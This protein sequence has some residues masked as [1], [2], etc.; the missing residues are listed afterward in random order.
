[1]ARFRAVAV[2]GAP[3][4][5][6]RLAALFAAQLFDLVTFTQMIGQHGIGA[7]A[8]PLV[9]EGFVQY[10]LPLLI[11]SKLALVILVGSIVAL[12]GREQPER[13]TSPRLAAFVIVVA[14]AVGFAGGLSN[15]LTF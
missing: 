12:L 5:R 15:A 1:V 11:A 8:N 4:L 6:F 10:G 9:A 13:R 3:I 14:V 2:S 7:E